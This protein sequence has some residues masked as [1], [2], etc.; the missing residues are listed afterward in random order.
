MKI[1]KDYLRGLIKETLE[2]EANNSS[3]KNL[4]KAEAY[5]Q[6]AVKQYI[7]NKLSRP[8][9]YTSKDGYNIRIEQGSAI[10]GKQEYHITV[11]KNDD[12]NYARGFVGYLGDENKLM[13]KHM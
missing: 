8:H 9:T 2:M 5:A 1:T 4:D 13:I 6:T 10:S 3:K 12:P 7:T 11:R